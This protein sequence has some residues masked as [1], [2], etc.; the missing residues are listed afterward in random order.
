MVIAREGR[1]SDDY[2][3]SYKLIRVI[4]YMARAF[5]CTSMEQEGEET[6]DPQFYRQQDPLY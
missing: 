6:V 1:E 3:S 5:S 2:S 4:E